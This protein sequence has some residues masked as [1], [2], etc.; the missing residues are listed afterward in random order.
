MIKNFLIRTAP[1]ALH[2]LRCIAEV[3][4][5]TSERVLLSHDFSKDVDDKDEELILRGLGFVDRK[6]TK[7]QKTIG[8]QLRLDMKSPWNTMLDSD[9]QNPCV[10]V[11]PCVYYL[12]R[13]V[14]YFTPSKINI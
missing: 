1:A 12:I 5:T 6:E 11:L 9:C 2:M 8:L 13:F 3:Y 14:N 4:Q 7:N 10:A